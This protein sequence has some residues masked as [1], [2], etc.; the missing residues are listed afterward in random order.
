ME[1]AK[2]REQSREEFRKK[3]AQ[4]SKGFVQKRCILVNIV[5]KLNIDVAR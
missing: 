3:G 5:H 4:T 1:I 2:T